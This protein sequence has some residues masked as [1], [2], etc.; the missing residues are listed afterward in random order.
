MGGDMVEPDR[1]L[2]K[3]HWEQVHR[4]KPAWE[5]SWLQL[6]PAASLELIQRAGIAPSARVVDIGG[7]AS[8]LADFLLDAGFRNLTVLDISAT[9]L[10]EARARLGTRGALVRWVE[11][12]IAVADVGGPFDLWHDRAAF[13]FL[14]AAED[15]ARYVATLKSALSPAGVAILATF[16]EDGPST[17]SGLPVVRYTPNALQR[18]VGPEFELLETTREIHLTPRG[19]TQSFVY[20]SFRRMV[21]LT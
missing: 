3:N 12:D 14:T 20:C 21:G 4:S 13:H 2:R 1:I 19:N 6:R 8:R 18:E 10:A 17:C 11:A 16:A 15:R 5:R 9:A 7:G